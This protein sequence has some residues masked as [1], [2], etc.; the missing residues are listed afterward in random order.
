MKKILSKSIVLTIM[1]LAMNFALVYGST[2][3][4][5]YTYDKLSDGTIEIVK[6]EGSLQNVVIPSTIDSKQVSKIGTGAFKENNSVKTI[7][8]PEGVTKIDSYAFKKCPNL[9]TI[10]FPST[11]RWVSHCF[12]ELCPKLNYTMPANL[13]EMSD[14]SYVE[15]ATVTTVGTYNYDLANNVLPLVN[16]E[17][18][19]KG[20]KSLKMNAKLQKAAMQRAAEIAVYWDHE[21]PN[22]LSCFSVSSLIDGENIGA[23]SASYIQIMNA[24]M[25]SPGH[26]AAILRE[27]YNSIGIGCYQING[28]TY[29]VQLFSDDQTTSSNV[30]SGK[31]KD[32]VNKIDIATNEGRI[33]L[34]ITGLDD[35]I[36]LD[37]GDTIS[38]TKAML[39]NDI[40]TTNAKT[41]IDLSDITWTSSNN[42][43]FTVDNSGTITAVGGG[44]ATLTATLG[45]ACLTYTVNVNSPLI[46]ISIPETLTVY[47]GYTNSLNIAYNPENTSDNKN[48]IWSSSNE[49]IAKVDNNG[50]ITGINVGTAVITAKVGNKVDTC[51]VTVKK[52][53]EEN[54]YF[55]NSTETVLITQ[56]TTLLEVV[57]EPG[58]NTK[59]DTITWKS[60]DSDIA[61]VDDNGIVT[62]LSTGTVT[63]SAIT[64]NGNVATCELN[65]I[66]YL[67]GDL[68]K[69]GVVNANDAAIALDLYKYGNVTNEDIQIGDLNGD[70]V[71]N[72]NDAALILDMY[73]YGSN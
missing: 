19:K 31:E 34:V 59:D 41:P 28:M 15:V 58:T 66:D 7:T 5:Q 6:Y 60:S 54:I 36:S 44:K 27:R 40:T 18:E 70:N 65:V 38:P 55:T 69:N 11:L 35:E 16:E 68:D 33:N 52:A 21:R 4:G 45:E 47:T 50:N 53:V 26:R 49:N 73:K 10:S 29:W 32:V 3:S 61:V 20:L 72:A 14:G 64:A 22:T 23:G 51:L 2:T 39:L 48:A 42:K 57:F 24:W 56:E 12:Y 63:I 9:T 62:I 71:V 46:S 67:K 25:N 8:I 13:K 1:F 37:I 30:I 43:V 17:R